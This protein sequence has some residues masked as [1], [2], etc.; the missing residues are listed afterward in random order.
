MYIGHV[1]IRYLKKKK[2]GHGQVCIK[3]LYTP[4][5]SLQEM[6]WEETVGRGNVVRE[7]IIED[8]VSNRKELRLYFIGSGQSFKN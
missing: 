3:G 5:S 8:L 6:E 4:K 2:K 1:I 7:Q